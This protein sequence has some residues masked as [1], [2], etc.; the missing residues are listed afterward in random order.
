LSFKKLEAGPTP[1]SGKGKKE[2]KPTTEE[3]QES[4]DHRGE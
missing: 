3:F 2:R 1:A 4:A